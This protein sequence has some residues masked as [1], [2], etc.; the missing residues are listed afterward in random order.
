MRAWREAEGLCNRTLQWLGQSPRH[1]ILT[2]ACDRYPTVLRTSP[3]PPL[4]LHVSGD[5]SSLAR[6]KVAVVGSRSAS[7]QGLAMARHLGQAW[8]EQGI[9]IV[10]G[11]ALG[12]DAAAHAGGLL[13]PGGSVAVV[14]CGLDETY[15]RSHAALRSRIEDG[16]CCLS[17]YPLGTPARSL[18]FPARNRII[19][20]LSQAVVVVEA[21]LRSGSLITARLANEAGREVLAVPGAL[22]SPLSAGPH[23]LIRQGAMLL[24]DPS[25]LFEALPWLAESLT[26]APGGTTAT[27]GPRQASGGALALSAQTRSTQDVRLAGAT[28][29]RGRRAAPGWIEVEL[30]GGCRSLDELL[31]ASNHDTTAAQADLLE[32]ELEGSVVRLPGGRYQWVAP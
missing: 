7:P 17:E 24:T 26:G 19:A 4:L 20:G 21:A 18:H 2:L 14:G 27:V 22:S 30:R 29:R 23:A 31:S 16:G 10:A 11:L 32:A 1:G 28:P 25:D 5:F 3:D 6:L 12:I 9:C 13:G 15:P 8:S